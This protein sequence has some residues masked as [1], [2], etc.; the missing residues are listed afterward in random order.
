MAVFECVSIGFHERV[1]AG[2]EFVTKIVPKIWL[3][4][5]GVT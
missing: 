2:F 1:L 5:K 3:S 4:V